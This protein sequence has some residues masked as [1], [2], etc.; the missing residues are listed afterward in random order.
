MEIC[1]RKPF[2]RG[3][4]LGVCSNLNEEESAR[5]TALGGLLKRIENFSPSAFLASFSARLIFQKTIYLLQAFGLYFGY[6]FSWYIR[7]PYSPALTREGYGLVQ[8]FKQAPTIRFRKTSSEERFNEF[9]KF[10]G[11][12]K[13]DSNWL[14]TLASIHFLK[15]QYP[16]ET[17]EEIIDIV[18]EKQ[19]YLTVEECMKAWTHLEK[20]G[21]VF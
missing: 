1:P 21:L 5:K 20:F 2:L 10:L 6:R 16:K 11:N 8:G 4:G 12:R 19:P 9:L 7:G 13:N 15:H 14:E 18:L 3:D 17:K